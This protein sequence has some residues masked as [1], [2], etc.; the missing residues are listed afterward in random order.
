MTIRNEMLRRAYDGSY[1]TITG[2]GG[3][4]Q[5][6]KD[7]YAAMLKER[8]IGTITEWIDFTGRDMNE[9]FNL[10]DDNRY[11]NDIHFLAFPLDG[12]NVNKLAV[13]K[14]EMRDRWFDDIVDNNARRE[15]E[16]Q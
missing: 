15:E 12:L 8:E 10:T 14:I 4:L 9:E 13:F 2:A 7:G 11:P 16:K 1:Y 5:E 6:W 3:D